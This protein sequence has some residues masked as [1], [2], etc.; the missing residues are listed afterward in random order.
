MKRSSHVLEVVALAV[1]TTVVSAQSSP[2]AFDWFEYSGT[3]ALETKVGAGEFQN[4]ILTG[5]YPDPSITRRG[6]DY[7]L[8]SSSFSSL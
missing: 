5:F 3:N 4:P 2:V 7:Y 8:V 1:A 6:D